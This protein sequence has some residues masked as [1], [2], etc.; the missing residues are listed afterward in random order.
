MNDLDRVLGK[1][2]QSVDKSTP[3]LNREQI[4]SVIDDKFAQ[5]LAALDQYRTVDDKPK[6]VN[7]IDI[8]DNAAAKLK[9]LLASED[10]TPGEIDYDQINARL[11]KP[12]KDSDDSLLSKIGGKLLEWSTD[13]FGQ[14][15]KLVGTVI[16]WSTETF[17]GLIGNVSRWLI[18]KIALAV[19]IGTVRGAAGAVRVSRGGKALRALGLAAGVAGS[20]FAAKGIYDGMN[21]LESYASSVDDQVQ[22]AFPQSS[23]ESNTIDSV[24]QALND[25]PT[26]ASDPSAE[27]SDEQPTSDGAPAMTPSEP[28]AQLKSIESK[29][30]TSD[31]PGSSPQQQ[32]PPNEATPNTKKTDTPTEQTTDKRD[33]VASPT[34]DLQEK[35][36]QSAKA[37]GMTISEYKN[38]LVKI[39]ENPSA[40]ISQLFS[41]NDTEKPP[42]QQ[43]SLI[44]TLTQDPGV[45]QSISDSVFSEPPPAGYSL[46]PPAID[47]V[48]ELPRKSIQN[49][50]QNAEKSQL[51]PADVSV[52]LSD[53]IS[54]NITQ[55]SNSNIPSLAKQQSSFLNISTSP[56]EPTQQSPVTPMMK[57]SPITSKP[58][59]KESTASSDT[60]TQSKKQVIDIH[61]LEKS[62]AQLNEQDSEQMK[63]ISNIINNL[64]P[65]TSDQITES[66]N[67][68]IAPPPVTN[69]TTYR[70]SLRSATSNSS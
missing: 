4:M 62:I 32:Q 54:T 21:Q 51:K 9:N 18:Q 59:K 34:K 48:D 56:T 69:M 28:Q 53:Q 15:F 10:K 19:G 23:T 29:P 46:R 44:E 65:P 22:R 7:I 60:S 33:S 25:T 70:D 13:M 38:V 61:N 12:N 14:V 52:N 37:Y 26:K 3:G 57:Q 43:E 24:N 30:E 31:S 63:N 55:S 5:T 39:A 27:P 67:K 58:I 35:I 20:G 49:S 66:P 1:I 2:E 16:R 8:S 42:V 41:E 64:S 68:S 47:S 6:S 50:P 40:N 17:L 11:N 36:E 45:D